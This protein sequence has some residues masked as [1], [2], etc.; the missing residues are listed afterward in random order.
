MTRYVHRLTPAR[1][2]EAT[3]P[4]R[5]ADGAG[6]YLQTSHGGGKSWLLRYQLNGKA[7]WMGLGPVD[8]GKLADS[9]SGARKRAADAQD[10]I[11]GGGDPLAQRRAAD[12][13]RK[14]ATAITFADAAQQYMAKHAPDWKSRIHREQWRSTLAMYAYPEIGKL[15][16]DAVTV[17]HVKPVL[18]N[19]WRERS[20][21]A[22]RLR[23]RIE[24]VLDFAALSKWRTGE[25]PFRQNIVRELLGRGRPKPKHHASM[26]YKD[27]PDFMAKLA[28]REDTPALAI[29][30]LVLTACRSSEGRYARWAEI[31]RRKAT[32][33]IPG[34]RMKGGVAHVVPLSSEA[35]AIL[36]AVP[37]H[38]GVEFVFIGQGG[39]DGVSDTAC[40]DVLRDLG[41]TK[42]TGTLHGF[43][44]SF[45]TWAAETGIADDVAEACLA[46]AIPDAVVKAYKRTK[47]DAARKS[48]MDVWAACV[49]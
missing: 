28:E 41:V 7:S 26:P 34:E 35:L 6:L 25:N 36:D 44:S 37:R 20:E 46:H 1:I 38:P 8:V 10:Y 21:T 18:E 42:D 33:T 45:R 4:G 22:R 5:Y 15:P 13:P 48:V 2:M 16:V 29:R 32:W 31:D 24:R 12:G 40:R 47:F 23:A 27:V 9:L 39:E 14:A 19:I 43:R 17:D 30:W 49:A 11:R 3:K